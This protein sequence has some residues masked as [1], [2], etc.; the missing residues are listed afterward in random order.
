MSLVV[1]WLRLCPP[2]AVGLD[3]TSGQR[4]RSYMLQLGAQMPQVKI[5]R[6]ATKT[7]CSQINTNKQINVFT[8]TYKSRSKTLRS[9][10]N[11]PVVNLTYCQEGLAFV[12]EEEKCHHFEVLCFNLTQR[13]LMNLETEKNTFTFTQSPYFSACMHFMSQ[14]QQHMG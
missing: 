8:K 10:S 2:S 6:A 7:Q 9:S 12:F 4:A 14:Q 3:L 1:Q 11:S 5:P 13:T